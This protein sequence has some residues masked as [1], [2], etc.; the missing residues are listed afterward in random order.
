MK[1]TKKYWEKCTANDIPNV[2]SIFFS[3]SAIASVV[4]GL[5]AICHR[6]QKL[7]YKWK[8]KKAMK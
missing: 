2:M 4:R 6:S 7:G 8:K 3:V 1:K 5:A